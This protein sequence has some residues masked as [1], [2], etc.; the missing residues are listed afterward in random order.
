MAP[1]VSTATVVTPCLNAEKLIART[2]ESLMNQTA[3]RSG[4]L[5]L[6][7]VVCDG[8]STDGTVR[9]VEEICEGRADVVSA[10]DRS[11]YDALS[12]GLRRATGEIVSYLNAGDYYSPTALDVVA[13]V[14]D[15]HA[16]VEWLTG[17]TVGYN[18]RG[19]VIR[20]RLPC[21]YRRRFARKALYGSSLLPWFIQQESTFWRRR[22]LSLVDLDALAT[23][24]LAGDSYLWQCFAREADLVVVESYLGGFA[25]HR[26]QLSSDLEAYRRELGALRARASALDIGLAVSDRLEQWAPPQVRKR[27]NPRG[28][29]RYSVQDEQW[30]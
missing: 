14:F 29:I 1:G 4:R 13:D 23:Y 27:L 5:T 7:Y 19:Q 24:R 21:R 17:L 12:T 15:A 20:A 30:L 6:Q 9:I 10:Q 16:N 8:A 22:L 25:Y 28:L 3:V 11:M 26:H 2:A 18:D